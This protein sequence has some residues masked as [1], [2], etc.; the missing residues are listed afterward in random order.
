MNWFRKERGEGEVV[1]I[2]S[3]VIIILVYEMTMV[4]DKGR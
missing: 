2:F 4:Q 1:A 3:L